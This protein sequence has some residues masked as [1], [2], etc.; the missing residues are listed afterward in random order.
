MNSSNCQTF[1]FQATIENCLMFRAAKH[2][3]LNRRAAHLP[4]IW[5]LLNLKKCCIF[6]HM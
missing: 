3:P 2:L 4:P 5:G 6:A 1:E